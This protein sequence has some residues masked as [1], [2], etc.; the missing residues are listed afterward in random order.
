[1]NI[2]K[3]LDCLE[4]AN[5]F[6]YALIFLILNFSINIPQL[7]YAIL[8]WNLNF[9]GDILINFGS[10]NNKVN[11]CYSSACNGLNYYTKSIL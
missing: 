9:K 2:A 10:L 11:P 7:K 5:A 8:S 6:L 1:M 4:K 3:N